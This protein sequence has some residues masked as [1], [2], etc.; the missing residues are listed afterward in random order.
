MKITIGEKLSVGFIIILIIMMTDSVLSYI[1]LINI[2][3]ST[4][5]V[6]QTALKLEGI[7]KLKFP[8]IEALI[9]NDYLISGDTSKRGHFEEMSRFAEEAMRDI[10]S[11]PFSEEENKFLTVIEKYFK[12]VK[13]KSDEVLESSGFTKKDFTGPG[14]NEIIEEIDTAAAI[15]VDSIEDLDVSIKRNLA[16]EIKGSERIKAVGN[17][18]IIITSTIAIIVG[19]IAWFV[20]SRSITTPVHKLISATKLIARGDFNKR[21]DIKSRDEIGELSHTFNKMSEDLMKKTTSVENLNREIFRR[22][23]AEEQIN[24]SLREKEILLRE[25]YHRNKNNMQVICSILNLQSKYTKDE[26]VLEIF[27][28]MDNRIKS[29]SLVHSK[30]YQ[31][32]D[33]SSINLKDY[34]V[35]LAKTLFS[36]YQI[37]PN[38][39]VLKLTADDVLVTIDSAVPC[40]LVINEII[41]NSLKYAFTE[42]RNGEIRIDL[43]LTG[44]GEIGLKI[45]DNGIGMPKGFNPKKAKTLGIQIVYG[46]VENQLNGKIELNCE[47]GAEYLIKFKEQGYTKRV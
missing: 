30:L 17:L 32:K 43:Y 16:E 23:C 38:H 1:S 46:L 36:A 11:L 13:I 35:D 5:L 39:I 25:I 10:E 44:E 18:T 26:Y 9:V 7:S 40:G 19:I 47:N 33:L 45:A 24:A 20:L 31:A 4:D 28:E 42:G 34:I 3:R 8:L 6:A 41:S 12:V 15:V 29:M 22:K 2:K 14:I 21:I 27:K 37:D